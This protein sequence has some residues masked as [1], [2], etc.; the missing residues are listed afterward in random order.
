MSYMSKINLTN[1]PTSEQVRILKDYLNRRAQHQEQGEIKLSQVVKR[2]KH[3]SL[4]S[5]KD[6]MAHFRKL[7]RLASE[8]NN[9][10]KDT[11]SK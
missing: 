2:F 3:K 9:V 8:G 5:D 1:K 7:L 4:M 11:E 10:R 6:K